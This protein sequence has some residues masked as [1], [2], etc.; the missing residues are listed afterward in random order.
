MT[1]VDLAHKS[2]DLRPSLKIL[3]TSGYVGEALQKY[4]DMPANILFIQKPFRADELASVLHAVMEG[5]SHGD[6]S[7][8]AV[9]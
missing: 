1:G 8:P 4:A 5:H 2:I 3:L 6:V 7:H 9:V